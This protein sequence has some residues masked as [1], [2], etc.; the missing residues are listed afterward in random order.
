MSCRRDCTV[1]R[2]RVAP[3]DLAFLT[4][5]LDA[6]DGIAVLRT[7]DYRLGLIEF[8]V[9][10]DFYADFRLIMENMMGQ[11]DLQIRWPEE[12]PPDPMA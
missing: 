1:V 3:E 2:A 4:A 12:P 7:A 8:W 10:P 5:T 9:A 6:Y 11:I